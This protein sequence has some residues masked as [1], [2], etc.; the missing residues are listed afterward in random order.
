MPAQCCQTISSLEMGCL[1]VAC[2]L[3]NIGS[4]WHRTWESAGLNWKEWR[5]LQKIKRNY[6]NVILIHRRLSNFSAKSELIRS[7]SNLF[8]D[9]LGK[10]FRHDLSYL[11]CDVRNLVY[12]VYTPLSFEIL[13]FRT[14]RKT[15][16]MKTFIYKELL[17]HTTPWTHEHSLRIFRFDKFVIKSWA[18]SSHE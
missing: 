1:R 13:T 17:C 18:F 8:N 14:T 2:N 10:H 5:S 11:S 16:W 12:N 9:A 7:M 15:G 3:C 4:N 6:F